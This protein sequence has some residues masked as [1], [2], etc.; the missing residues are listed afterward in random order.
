[1]GAGWGTVLTYVDGIP[2]YWNAGDIDNGCDVMYGI[3]YQCVELVQR[4]FAL[5][6]GYP[7]IWRGVGGAADM[8][9]HHPGDIQFIP[10]GGSP[11]PREGDALLFY[12]GA[13]GHIAIIQRVDRHAGQIDIAEENWSPSGQASLSIYPDNSISIRDSNAGSYTIAGWLHSPLNQAA[14]PA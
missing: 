3:A 1:L 13:F 7:A 8:R 10:N 4:Y 9:T 2:V 11:G 14:E 5:R 12:G 6:W